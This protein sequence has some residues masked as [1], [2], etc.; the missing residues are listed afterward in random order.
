MS[1]LTYAN[2]TE[3]V[4]LFHTA[5]DMQAAIDELQTHGFDRADL[6]VMASEHA[7]EEKFKGTYVPVRDLEDRPDVPTMAY[8][9]KEFLGAPE[10]AL[11]GAFMY[12]PAVIG[13]AAVV[14]SG[15]SLAAAIAAVAITTGAGGA[16]GAILARLIDRRYAHQIEEHLALGGLLLW[17]A[18]RDKEHVETAMAVMREH[19]AE[20]AH[21]HVLPALTE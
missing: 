9:S 14:A 21:T 13:L 3:V 19:G 1:R 16:I 10:G 18:T 2:R 4:G 5:K 17:A 20:D 12:V 7:I 8:V 15:G 6:S 11:V